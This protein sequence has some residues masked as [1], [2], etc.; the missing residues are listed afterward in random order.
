M[1]GYVHQK[2]ERR[3]GH[4]TRE[5][6]GRGM[7]GERWRRELVSTKA[8]VKKERWRREF[9]S[10]K[11]GVKKEWWCREYGQLRVS[12]DELSIVVGRHDERVARRHE[13]GWTR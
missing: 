10:T 3:K 7:D 2:K 6:N 1:L 9:V 13:R 12:R 4:W 8:G 5:V 11:A